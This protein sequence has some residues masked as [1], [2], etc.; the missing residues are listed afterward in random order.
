MDLIKLKDKEACLLTCSIRHA[1]VV[2]KTDVELLLIDKE[3][4][5]YILE[6]FLRLR[7]SVISNLIRSGALVVPNI[8]ISSFIVVV[9]S[10]A[11]TPSRPSANLRGFCEREHAEALAESKDCS[12]SMVDSWMMYSPQQLVTECLIK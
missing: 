5:N 6:D 7:Y 3:D 2:C 1:T 12:V 10:T 8:L 11:V 9:K 4:F